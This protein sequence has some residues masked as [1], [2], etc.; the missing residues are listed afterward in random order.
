MHA[1]G[2]QPKPSPREETEPSHAAPSA[3]I[4]APKEEL[5][6]DKTMLNILK[7]DRL[8]CSRQAHI[9]LY[10]RIVPRS[11]LKLEHR[12]PGSLAPTALPRPARP[13]TSMISLLYHRRRMRWRHPLHP[14]RHLQWFPRR[15][16]PQVCLLLLLLLLLV[17]LK[18]LNPSSRKTRRNSRSLIPMIQTSMKCY[19]ALT[20][21]RFVFPHTISHPRFLHL[22]KTPSTTAKSPAVTTKATA[23]SSIL[24]LDDDDEDF[25]S[26]RP[27][28]K[29]AKPLDNDDIFADVTVRSPQTNKAKKDWS[30]MKTSA[31]D[32]TGTFSLLLSHPK[33]YA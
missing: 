27:V 4:D 5:T 30:I 8:H 17:L 31:T 16:W 24:T 6:A 18:K 10:C 25:L 7:V 26:R 22:E 29:I 3:S 21:V 32:D 28:R 20:E 23:R 15:R 13:M 14:S 33:L 11:P 9:V 2:A 1:P 19:S 12:P